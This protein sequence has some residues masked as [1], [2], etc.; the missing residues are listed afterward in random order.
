MF[1]TKICPWRGYCWDNSKWKLER[2][3]ITIS[4]K[5]KWSFNKN[6]ETFKLKPI[7]ERVYTT[8]INKKIPTDYLKAINTV[9]SDYLTNIND[10]M[11]WDINVSIYT[12]AFT[13]KQ[14]LNDLKEIKRNINANNT[15]Q[16][17]HW[18]PTQSKKQVSKEIWQ[19]QET[20][21][22]IEISSI[23]TWP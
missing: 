3:A 5:L 11:F 12:T 2:W 23:E 9:A 15:S 20:Y 14:E 10:I 22:W 17:I 8:K 21:T 1:L 6:F 7:E 4:G 18:T 13:A 16:N 19:F